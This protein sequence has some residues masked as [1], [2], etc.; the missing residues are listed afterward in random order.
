MT[1]S[2]EIPSNLVGYCVVLLC[3][4]HGGGCGSRPLD[5]RLHGSFFPFICVCV[6]VGET[7]KRIQKVGFAAYSSTDSDPLNHP[8]FRM[9]WYHVWSLHAE[10]EFLASVFFSYVFLIDWT[11]PPKPRASKVNIGEIV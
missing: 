2:V 10:G 6:F 11:Q 8:G 4:K 5:S 1:N 3:A 7:S 9:F